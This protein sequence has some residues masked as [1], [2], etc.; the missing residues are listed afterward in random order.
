MAG[1]GDD[2]GVRNN[3]WDLIEPITIMDSFPASFAHQMGSTFTPKSK[4]I[5]PPPS[6]YSVHGIRPGYSWLLD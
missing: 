2:G 3:R 4:K 5:M 6:I 1:D